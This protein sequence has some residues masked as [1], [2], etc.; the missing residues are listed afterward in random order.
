MPSPVGHALGGLI[1]GLALGHPPALSERQRVDGS[2]VNRRPATGHRPPSP[3]DLRPDSTSVPTPPPSPRDLRPWRTSVPLISAVAACL[4]DLDFLWGR[5]NMET[6]SLGF[7]LL[8]GVVVYAWQRST[9]VAIACA[10]AVASHVLFDWLGSDDT[11]PLGV[12]ALWPFSNAFYFA[13]AFVF[14]A[15]SRRYWL[16]NFFTHNL[17]AVAREVAILLP[18]AIAVRFARARQK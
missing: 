5:H 15:I 11:P 3:G 9:R 17:L 18:I 8:V 6:H 10:V 12:M 13:N 16:P 7:A 4:P 1:I 2:S 14:E